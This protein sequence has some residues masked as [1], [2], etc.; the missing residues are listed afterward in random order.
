VGALFAFMV[1]FDEI[2]IALF[3][4]GPGAT[5]MPVKMWL[6]MQFSVNPPI[7]AVSTMVT[8]LSIVQFPAMAE[9]RRRSTR[10]RADPV[11]G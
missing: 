8:G 4:A 9:V 1:S 6:S 5:P 2:V 3:V 11:N 10:R 7:A